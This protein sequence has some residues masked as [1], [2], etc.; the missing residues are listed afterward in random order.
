MI[1]SPWS[2]VDQDKAQALLAQQFS[3]HVETPTA[4]RERL[5]RLYLNEGER[6]HALT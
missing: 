6:N 4:C 2:T 1:S 5:L 3:H